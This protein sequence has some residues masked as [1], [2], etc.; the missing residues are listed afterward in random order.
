M[1][2]RHNK[3]KAPGAT[4]TEGFQNVTHKRRNFSKSTA[5]EAQCQGCYGAVGVAGQASISALT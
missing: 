2:P 1:T 5:T 4:N 3:Q